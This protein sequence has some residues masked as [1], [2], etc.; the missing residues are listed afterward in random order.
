MELKFRIVIFM[1]L[2]SVGA[3]SQNYPSKGNYDEFKV[4]D[5]ILPD[6]LTMLNGKKVKWKK[7]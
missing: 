1:L 7:G 3:R 4:S 5:Y 2:I 6:P